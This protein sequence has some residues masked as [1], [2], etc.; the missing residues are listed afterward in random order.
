[1]K[2]ALLILADGF[3]EI[4]AIAVID[5]LRRGGVDLTVA[6]LENTEITGGQGLEVTAETTL[7]TITERPFDIVILPGGDDGVDELEKSQSLKELIVRR[8]GK[9]QLIAAICAAPRLLDAWGVLN[10]R[11][12]TSYPDTRPKLKACRYSEDQVVRDGHVLTSRGPG[13]AMAFGYAILEALGQAS[14]ANILRAGM[15]FQK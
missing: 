5:I 3:E 12:A 7:E 10:N 13:T 4:E 6:G 9:E 8:H 1:M 15:V 2:T 14:T 11:V